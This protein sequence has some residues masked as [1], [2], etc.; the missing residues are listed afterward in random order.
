MT[1]EEQKQEQYNEYGYNF[2][3]HCG[4]TGYVESHHIVYRSEAPNHPMLHDKINRILLTRKCHDWFHERKSNRDKIVEE[5]GLRN[6]FK[7]T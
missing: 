6:I 3:E 4:R 5:R 2:C 1:S 7:I